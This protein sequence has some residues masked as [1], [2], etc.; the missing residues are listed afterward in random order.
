MA[1]THHNNRPRRCYDRAGSVITAAMIA[2]FLFG[3]P[4]AAFAAGHWVHASTL[5]TQRAQQATRQQTR[6]VLLS[7]VRPAKCGASMAARWAAPDGT[8]RTGNITAMAGPAVGSTMMVWTDASGRLTGP[9][10]RQTTAVDRGVAAAV[11]AALILGLL[12]LGAG[13]L[14]HRALT[15]HRLAAPDAD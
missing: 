1:D 10:W 9:P 2:A 15:R 5:S 4:A 11:L 7:N 12:L 8:A 6:A 3:A 13:T 14:A